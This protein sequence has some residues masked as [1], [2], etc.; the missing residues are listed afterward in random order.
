MNKNTAR[1]VHQLIDKASDV[2]YNKH[3][4][5]ADIV[6]INKSYYLQLLREKHD[7]R[8]SMGRMAKHLADRSVLGFEIRLH[9]RKK[10]ILKN[11][12]K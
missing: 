6:Y 7:L 10:I 2:F 1:D 3:G 8:K 11:Y 5:E 12:K 4:Y 9:R